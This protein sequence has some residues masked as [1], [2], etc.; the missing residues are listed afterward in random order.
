[1][2]MKG[3]KNEGGFLFAFNL[4]PFFVIPYNYLH[5]DIVGF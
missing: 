3:K 2:M 1:M 4:H 5:F